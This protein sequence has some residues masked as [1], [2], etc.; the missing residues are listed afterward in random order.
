ML[1][2]FAKILKPLKSAKY[3][4]KLH[5]NKKIYTNLRKNPLKSVFPLTFMDFHACISAHD[6]HHPFVCY[7]ML[8]IFP[9]KKNV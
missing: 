9:F 3:F 8:E 4:Q 6:R 7:K 1:Q 5:E 2:Y